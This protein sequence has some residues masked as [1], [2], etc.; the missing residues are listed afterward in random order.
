MRFVKYILLGLLLSCSSGTM[1]E[2]IRGVI[3]LSSWDLDKDGSLSLTGEWEFYFE[4]Y[5]F[6]EDFQKRKNQTN[7]GKNPEE[8]AMIPSPYF[9][10]TPSV[11]KGIEVNGKNLPGHGYATYRMKIILGENQKKKLAFKIKDQ[12]HAYRF[13]LGEELVVESG[14]VGVS[15]ETMTPSVNLAYYAFTPDKS[16]LEL[17]FHVS[18]FLHRVGG[19][20]FEITLGMDERLIRE[21]ERAFILDS[22]LFGGF[23]IIAVYHLAIYFFRR[24]SKAPLYFAIFCFSILIYSMVVGNRFLYHYFPNV[25]SWEN[26]YRLEFICISFI[27]FSVIGFFTSLYPLKNKILVIISWTGMVIPILFLFLVF[28]TKPVVFTEYLF[29]IEFGN[30]L[31]GIFIIFNLTFSVYKR[32]E[33]SFIF[34]FGFLILFICAIIDILSIHSIIIFP[35]LL[36]YGL[37]AMV[38]MQAI[39]LAKIFTGDFLKS[40]ILSTSLAETN[41]AYSRFIPTEFLNLLNKESILDINLGDHTQREMTILFSDIRSFTSLSEKMTPTENFKF[42]NSYL[43]RIAPIIKMNHGFIDKYIGDAIMGLFPNNPDDAV[44]A[45]IAMQKEIEEYNKIRKKIGYTPVKVGIGLHTGSL[46]LGTIGHDE[47]MEGTVISNA[48]NLASRL[49]GLTK[50]YGSN[51]LIS[52][53]TFNNLKDPT[54]YKI[55]LLDNVLVKGKADSIFVIEILDGYPEELL[56]KFLKTK[57]DFETGNLLYKQKAFDASIEYFKKVLEINPLDTAT[58]FYLKRAEYYSINGAPPDW[59]G[60]EVF[61]DK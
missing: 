51:I 25:V 24:K 49:E 5:L 54:K 41:R 20:R 30:I 15:A 29:V 47:R 22:F 52:E 53:D 58:A 60:G 10:K 4:K 35:R 32:K 12:A 31:G 33:G 61:L 16:E 11:W 26:A 44:I 2:V 1:P 27:L 40:E 57:N 6:P 19:L 28:L 23:F 34:L 37:T 7:F 42:L 50:H 39:L 36:K 38:L 9:M 45:S 48:V 21:R 43:N 56:E 59:E 13:Y 8:V 18:N 17:I 46:I 3:D 55:R 14:K